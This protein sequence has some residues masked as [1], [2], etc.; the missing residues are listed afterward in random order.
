MKNKLFYLMLGFT[1]I[2]CIAYGY[3]L[4]NNYSSLP[5]RVNFSVTIPQEFNASKATL[6]ISATSEV[7][8]SSIDSFWSLE[9]VKL[10]FNLSGNERVGQSLVFTVTY[11]GGNITGEISGVNV[12]EN[13]PMVVLGEKTFYLELAEEDNNVTSTFDLSFWGL[14]LFGELGLLAVFGM[15][16]LLSF[17]GS[18]EAEEV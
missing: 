5:N 15:L 16:T 11:Y 7:W 3:G 9:K 8:K 12:V 17:L 4:V 2:I 10:P 14:L 18:S 13:Q 6:D 1:I